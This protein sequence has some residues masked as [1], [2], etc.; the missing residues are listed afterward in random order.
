MVATRTLVP[1]QRPDATETPTPAATP[2]P[3]T[4]ITK[5]IRPEATA[6]TTMADAMVA[7]G[8]MRRR[9]ADRMAPPTHRGFIVDEF[10]EST[11]TEK[12]HYVSPKG[13]DGQKAS[14]VFI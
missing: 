3:A 7:E 2:A 13:G 1:P 14:E 10:G 6:L 5:A 4:T 11:A 9:S 8:S 12:T